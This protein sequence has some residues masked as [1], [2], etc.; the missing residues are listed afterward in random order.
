ML[1]HLGLL[2]I[3]IL[4]LSQAANLIRWAAAPID[5]IGFW[6]LLIAAS[7]LLPS[8]WSLRLS[9]KQV[10]LK[11]FALNLLSGVFL[12]LHFWTFFYA[13]QNTKIANAMIIFATNPLFTALGA[14]LFF[15]EKITWRLALAYLLA[16]FGLFQLLNQSIKFSTEQLNG[17][18]S[19][20][21]SAA[22]FSG[23]IL[24]G[25]GIRPH[26]DN[27]LYAFI[28]YSVTAIL[29]GISALAQDL[30]FLGYPNK[31]WIAIVVLAVVTTLMGH[32]LFTYLLKY[33]NVNT[34]SCAK[35]IEPAL[36]ALVAFIAF[37]E[38]LNAQTI[39]A[40]VF[41]ATA[42]LVLFGPSLIK[43]KTQ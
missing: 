33:I 10:P 41:T 11:F 38:N 40:F 8:A 26:F 1:R 25:R 18:L 2:F 9:L 31:T 21:I 17:D 16:G 43:S 15:K 32:A 42:V 27:R 7:L 5:V 6:R 29:F 3:A 39:V 13:A 20:L 30:N 22:L 24:S 14:Y 35:L 19:A 28:I 12:F 37:G 23:Y 4:S 36:S 34:L